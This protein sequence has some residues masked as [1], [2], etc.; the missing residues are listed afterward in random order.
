LAYSFGLPVIATDVGS[1]RDDIVEGRTGYV[2][3]PCDA[4]DLAE[5]IERYF[6]NDLYLTLES[7]RAEI[8][9]FAEMRNSWS[10]VGDTI[11][12]E[13]AQLLGRNK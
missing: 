10:L 3:R 13:Y 12:Q 7:R 9:A 4:G 2:C 1:L 6:A 11:C 8:K 5:S